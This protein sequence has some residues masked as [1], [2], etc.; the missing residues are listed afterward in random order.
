MT[1]QPP[2]STVEQRLT[3]V[4]A[5]YESLSSDLH[6]LKA[7]IDVV[8][9]EMRQGFTELRKSPVDTWLKAGAVML[10]IIG[11]VGGLV[12]YTIQADINNVA[13]QM[14]RLREHYGNPEIAKTL[15]R[16]DVT[17][18]HLAAES[19]KRYA[20]FVDFL[21]NNWSRADMEKFIETRFE[22]LRERVWEMVKS[23]K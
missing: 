8:A 3:A 21:R 23:P 2:K 7:T 18:R 14:G 1:P 15:E 10:T 20:A 17:L 6:S 4:E 5:S 12:A 9:Q 11:M 16:H 13:G 22:P 19:E